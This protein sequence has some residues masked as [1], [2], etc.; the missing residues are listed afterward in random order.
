MYVDG[1]I[2]ASQVQSGSPQESE[3]PNESSEM[4]N[5]VGR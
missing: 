1:T 2:G 4:G 5:Y 3:E